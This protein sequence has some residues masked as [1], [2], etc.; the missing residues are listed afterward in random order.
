MI[1]G[2]HTP[3]GP[4]IVVGIDGPDEATWCRLVAG[5]PVRDLTGTEHVVVVA[6]HP[7]DET[8]GLGGTL[9]LLVAA[10]A[11][12]DLV[13]VT[14]GEA[15][16][17]GHHEVAARRRRE[18]R[19]ALATLRIGS[20]TAVHLLGVPDGQVAA[21]TARVEDGIG[22]FVT[23]RSLVLAPLLDD[24]HPDHEAAGRA[25]VTV[26]RRVGSEVLTY[27]VWAWQAHDPAT[28]DLLEHAWRVPLGPE[29]LARK[30]RAAIAFQSQLDDRLGPPIVPPHVL[31]RLLRDDEVLVAPCG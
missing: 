2:D 7:D 16:H 17:P 11:D 19:I 25:A 12:V 24:G 29:V 8:F 15:S 18:L 6:P 20:S 4:T 5:L 22:S 3:L 1:R 28:S 10:G 31:E 13:T 30:R 9:Q 27:P 23:P 14:D 26:A 21:H